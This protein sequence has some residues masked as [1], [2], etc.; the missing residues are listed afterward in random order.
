MNDWAGYF[1]LLASLVIAGVLGGVIGLER[2]IHGRW[3]GLRTHILVSM[4]AALFVLAIR[5]VEH[6]SSDVS[7]VI[8]GIATGLG[9]IGGGTI[10]KLTDKHQV[11]GLTTASTIWMAASLGVVAGLKLYLLAA[12]ATFLALV[13]LIVLHWLERPLSPRH[14]KA[15]PW[16]GQSHEEEESKPPE[17]H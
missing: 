15:V 4:G 17:R 8:Q 7:R 6:T 9:F 13:V 10:L 2:E 14:S 11:K 12:T 1:E 5:G 16:S 3:A